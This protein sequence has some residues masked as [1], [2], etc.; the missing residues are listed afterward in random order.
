MIWNLPE[1]INPFFVDHENSLPEVIARL[2]PGTCLALTGPAG[3]GKTQLA[4]QYAYQHRNEYSTGIM[5]VN[6]HNELTLLAGFA[7]LASKENLNLNLSER[8]SVGEIIPAVIAELESRTGWLLIFDNCDWVFEE[9]LVRNLSLF[10]SLFPYSSDGRILITTRFDPDKFGVETLP[11]H[12]MHVEQGAEFLLKRSGIIND[13]KLRKDVDPSFIEAARDITRMVDG[14]PLT[15]ELA[16]A[17]LAE[18][19]PVTPPDYL[20]RLQTSLFE[21]RGKWGV[22]FKPESVASACNVSLRAAVS[23]SQY[24]VNLVNLCVFFDSD[25]IP[26]HLVPPSLLVEMDM[27]RSTKINSQDYAYQVSEN[28]SLLKYNY[29]TS[30][31]SMHRTVQD[32]IR[33]DMDEPTRNLWRALA[34]QVLMDAAHTIKSTGE[35]GRPALLPHWRICASYIV[36]YHIHT[37]AAV[38][39]LLDYSEYLLEK[40]LYDE[41]KIVLHASLEVCETV[42]GSESPDSMLN[43]ANLISLGLIEG[44][45]EETSILYAKLSRGFDATLG[46]EDM[47]PT[48]SENPIAILY[49]PIGAPSESFPRYEAP[50]YIRIPRESAAETNLVAAY[51]NLGILYCM[52]QRHENAE[53]LF[54]K[55]MNS[56]KLHTSDWDEINLNLRYNQAELNR[57]NGRYDLAEKQFCELIKDRYEEYPINLA[58]ACNQLAK[59]YMVQ[60]RYD[61]AERNFLMALEIREKIVGLSSFLTASSCNN[62]G[63]FYHVTKKYAEAEAHYRRALSLFE[64]SSGLSHPNTQA[65]LVNF[66]LFLE[67]QGKSEEAKELRIKVQASQSVNQYGAQSIEFAFSVTSEY[68]ALS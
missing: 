32:A 57:I 21:L 62:L 30:S 65:T 66:A 40:G 8:L 37:E 43:I 49:S 31:L 11:M 44:S 38:R 67:Q 2:N 9:E 63:G 45:D 61:L 35:E 23:K 20:S 26:I 39:M 25:F 6:A 7:A 60:D 55:A 68:L 19:F 27:T 52:H 41:A 54:L 64:A 36:D 53:D 59:L 15:L 18:T 48:I 1:F 17:Y 12:S 3:I 5:W 33:N 29:E 51:N 13:L 10:T 14:L 46:E 56:R 50:R 16:G 58:F 22:T 34:I 4:Y 24:I 28:Y 42:N 47:D